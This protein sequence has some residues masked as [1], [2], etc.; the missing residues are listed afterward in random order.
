M[1][2]C[3]ATATLL[4]GS[5]VAA[6]VSYANNNAPG[7]GTATAS[8][9]AANYSPAP[10]TTT[11]TI[12]A[13]TAVTIECSPGA[14]YT[15]M[16]V[17]PCSGHVTSAFDGLDRPVTVTYSANVDAGTATAT[18]SYAAD[19]TQP[20]AS[21]LVYGG[22]TKTV[23]SPI[24]KA[25]SAVALSCPATAPVYTESAVTP[26]CT[27]TATGAGLS[28]PVPVSYAGNTGAGTAT[29][30]A[31]YDGDNNH[32]GGTGTTTFAIS[33]A[34]STVTVSCTPSAV[35]TGTPL[36]PVCT[37]SAGGAG[38]APT[39]VPVSPP[40]ITDVGTATVSATYGGDSNHTASTG[41]GTTTFAVTLG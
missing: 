15:G 20:E 28:T 36:S 30:T 22:A 38:L 26:A 6:G 4:N 2:P 33:K 18:A 25:P 17:T 39:S 35:Y 10:V 3:Q 7:T 8:Y 29:V 23:T 31:T 37:A 24:G 27:A 13:P 12:T 9:A 32:T 34:P 41:T 21:G 40:A 1:T 16:Q 19:A 11:F 14:V 5:T